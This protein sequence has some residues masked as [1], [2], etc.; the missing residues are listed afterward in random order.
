MKRASRA[1]VPALLLGPWLACSSDDP[2]RLRELTHYT[3]EMSVFDG[4]NDGRVLGVPL[5]TKRGLRDLRFEFHGVGLSASPQECASLAAAKVRFADQPVT[6]MVVGGWAVTQL[7]GVD[8]SHCEDPS[9]EIIFDDPQGEPQDGD[10]V[11]EDAGGHFVVPFHRPFGS[12]SITLVS[13]SRDKLVVRLS[14]FPQM[15][16]LDAIKLSFVDERGSS[17]RLPI[18]GRMF[19]NEGLLAVSVV[20]PDYDKGPLRG[21][22]DVNV[23][24]GRESHPCEGFRGCTT[25]S[26][27]ERALAVDLP[28]VP[29]PT[30]PVP[31][32]P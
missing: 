12:A 8:F 17:T 21:A 22:L 7:D 24:L 23:D 19:T 31:T 4:A 16:A 6:S 9:V 11:L 32:L 30:N 28:A 5:S 15:P 1:L 18:S 3:V 2:G 25:S 26:R 13:A 20:S 27:M 29:S 14:D 10:L